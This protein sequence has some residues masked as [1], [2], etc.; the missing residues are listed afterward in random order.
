MPLAEE[1]VEE[2]QA[3]ED[4]REPRQAEI[5]SYQ[6]DNLD[7]TFIEEAVFLTPEDREER[8][9]NFEEW[10][11]DESEGA[12][13]DIVREERDGL[14]GHHGAHH[15][16]H[17]EEHMVHAAS[18]RVQRRRGRKQQAGRRQQAE[19]A[20]QEERT[21]RQEERGGRQEERG[22]RQTGDIGFA[23]GPSSGVGVL[24]SPPNAAGDYNF[25]FAND[26]GTSRQET[27]G[28][29]GVSGSYSF[30]TPEGEE[31]S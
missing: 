13:E 16:D 24:S 29:E 1:Y 3:V 6:D 4:V 9:G 27:A 30:F 21:S 20:R 31:V 5:I 14:G 12:E 11:E 23:A 7:D 25:N 2:V 26:D 18:P 10:A 15:G 22:G 19:P 17:G 8:S 28:P